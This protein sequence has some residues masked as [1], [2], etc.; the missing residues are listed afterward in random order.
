MP[1]WC[2]TCER[3]L[4][5]LPHGAYRR[6]C[7]GLYWSTHPNHPSDNLVRVRA[8]RGTV[9]GVLVYLYG[10]YGAGKIT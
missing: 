9:T 1:D 6:C 3:S 4:E 5:R 8:A 10:V 2:A 7:H